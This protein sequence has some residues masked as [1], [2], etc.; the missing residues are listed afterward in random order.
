MCLL[1]AVA[2]AQSKA[3]AD[4][5]ES[6]IK[7]AQAV[8]GPTLTKSDGM[9]DVY[10]DIRD[11]YYAITKFTEDKALN[12]IVFYP[13]R[14]ERRPFSESIAEQMTAITDVEAEDWLQRAG[15]IRPLGTRENNGVTT[16]AP[17]RHRLWVDYYS[18]ADVR[19]VEVLTGETP[20]E[21]AWLQ[22]IEVFYPHPMG[23]MLVTGKEETS[24]DTEDGK[25]RGYFLHFVPAT[26]EV[27][28][29]AGEVDGS[30]PECAVEEK[31]Y[32]VVRPGD[33]IDGSIYYDFWNVCR[34]K[35]AQVIRRAPAIPPRQPEAK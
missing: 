9:D 28:A 34:I 33:T 1:C 26:A 14:N 2:S 22:S 20:N 13:K 17:D 24:F 35:S 3:P 18:D 31:L 8:F 12:A 29:H 32:S 15:R 5:R 19:Y 16:L 10:F 11:D 23:E 25:K 21:R 30:G 6:V 27:M 4:E 7:Q